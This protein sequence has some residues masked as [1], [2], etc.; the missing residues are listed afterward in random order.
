MTFDGAG[1]FYAT[2]GLVVAGAIVLAIAVMYYFRPRTRAHYPGGAGRYLLAITVQMVALLAPIPIVLMLLLTS[3]IAQELQ[4]ITAVVIG[5]G[6]VFGL[7]FAPG[8]G[9]LLRDLH[10]ARVEAM[11]DRLGRR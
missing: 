10:K 6:F 9:P 3:P 2:I 1:S 8:T 4:V 11:V 7:R 5:L